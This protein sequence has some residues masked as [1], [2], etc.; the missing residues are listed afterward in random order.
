MRKMR[1]DQ[2]SILCSRSHSWSGEELALEANQLVTE[3]MPLSTTTVEQNFHNQSSLCT[4]STRR[5]L[6]S[7]KNR[8]KAP[9]LC[10]LL[11]FCFFYYYPMKAFELVYLALFTNI[12]LHEYLRTWNSKSVMIFSPEQVAYEI[13]HLLYY[14]SIFFLR[15][16]PWI[17]HHFSSWGRFWI[18]QLNWHFWASLLSSIAQLKRTQ[19]SMVWV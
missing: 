3:F 4:V 19:K 8:H 5:N 14:S 16:S 17:T 11:I 13:K 6:G 12:K 15:F 7:T 10:N 1:T 18:T 2:S 9:S